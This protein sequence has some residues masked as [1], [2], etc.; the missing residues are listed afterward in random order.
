L[1]QTL[2]EDAANQGCDNKATFDLASEASLVDFVS[3]NEKSNR[4]DSIP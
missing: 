1:E 3:D 4:T 2:K